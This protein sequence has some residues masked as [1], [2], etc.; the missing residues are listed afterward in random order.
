MAFAC[1]VWVPPPR[2]LVGA[3]RVG[4]CD[5]PM[6]AFI[7]IGR[8]ICAI[9]G[10]MPPYAALLVGVDAAVR[11]RAHAI[12]LPTGWLQARCEAERLADCWTARNAVSPRAPRAD[13]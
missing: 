4:T 9:S 7:T 10:V 6:S 2:A 3:L 8:H 12:P 5:W 1:V 13:K 11:L